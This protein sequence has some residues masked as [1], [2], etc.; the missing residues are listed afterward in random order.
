ML[1][2][3]HSLTYKS[4]LLYK[5]MLSTWNYTRFISACAYAWQVFSH[6]A[7]VKTSEKLMASVMDADWANPV[8]Q[9]T[10]DGNQLA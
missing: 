4:T 7:S 3:R 2:Y 6:Q 10:I 9:T 5:R 1:S 8:V